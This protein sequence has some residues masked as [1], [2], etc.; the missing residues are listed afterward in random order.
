NPVWF[1][2]RGL[3]LFGIWLLLATL[4]NQSSRAQDID[5]NPARAQWRA[6]L[7]T[8]GIVIYVITVTLAST[9]WVMSLDPHWYST[10]WGFI[11]CDGQALGAMALITLIITQNA[12]APAYEGKLNKDV[13]RDL[14]NLLLTFT[15]VWAYFAVSQWII[16]WSG[17]LPDEIEY[18]LTRLK[19]PMLP[20]GT[21]I[22]IGQFFAPFVML[23]SSRAKRTP[24]ML[25]GIAVLILIVR[26]VEIFWIVKPM[27]PD[28]PKLPGSILPLSGWDGV[29][30]LALGGL[31]LG[32]FAYLLGK[33]ALFPNHTYVV[34]E[35]LENA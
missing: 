10:I 30:F 1:G 6:N 24:S 2:F 25:G 16:I 34:P 33:N 17:N 28:A 29:T 4:L 11:F 18:Y 12:H 21:F 35:V 26:V 22:V 9:D 14:G 13:T 3:I 5:G 23:L 32:G 31:W 7:G 15:M 8:A 20:V 19:G 27:F